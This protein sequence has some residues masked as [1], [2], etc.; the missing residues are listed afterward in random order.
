MSQKKKWS[1]AAKF[2]IV[3]LAIKNETT[4]NDICKRYQVS[5]C[6]VHKWKKQLLEQGAG[7]FDKNDKA[8]E[9]RTQALEEKQNQL[10]EKIGKLTIERDFLK[11]SWAKFQGKND[12]D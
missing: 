6:L 1:A 11:K 12:D 3:L 5:P 8:G 4:L 2:E 9:I 7:L 10:Y